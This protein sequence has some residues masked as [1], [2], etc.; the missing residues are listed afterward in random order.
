M[1][2]NEYIFI[3]LSSLGLGFIL[4]PLAIR[5]AHRF[6]WL[7]QPGHRKH[8][9]QAVA[10]LGG[11]A[12]FTSILLSLFLAWAL[13]FLS[14]METQAFEKIAIIL[15]CSLGLAVVGLWD[16]LH[17]VRA[18]YKLIGQVF[19]TALFA[20]FGFR[21]EVMHVPGLPPFPL[22][23]MSVPLTVFW[24][25]SV[26]NA[27]NMV[28]GLDGLASTIF[29]GSLLSLS[30]ASALAD[31]PG[32]MLLC[33]AAFGAVLGFLK[34]NWAPAKIYLGDCGSNGLAMLL[35]GLL[36]GLGQTHNWLPGI[37]HNP[38]TAGQPFHYQVFVLTLLVAY[39][40]LEIL[41][42]V[43]RRSLHGRPLGRA[44]RGHLHH[45]M[46]ALGLQK[47][48]ICLIALSF[49]L[50]TGWSA[51]AIIGHEFGR[52]TWLL[53][54]SGAL[55]GLSFPIL[56][57]LDF[58][59]PH[60]I[61]FTRP[62]FLISHHF[63]SMQKAKLGLVIHQDDVLQL[64]NQVCLEFGVQAYRLQ[65]PAGPGQYPCAAF[66]EKPMHEQKQYLTEIKTEILTG[67]FS[68]FKD[69]VEHKPT[70]GAANWIFEPHT[71]EDELDVEYHVLLS[72]FMREALERIAFLKPAPVPS[73]DSQP[74]RIPSPRLTS[75][76][77]RRRHRSKRAKV[78]L[79]ASGE[80]SLNDHSRLN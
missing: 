7:D 26:I 50:L 28:D 22:G 46:L 41:L 32:G 36:I 66:W 10:Y 6:S 40:A 57:F 78:P 1:I 56:G 68:V 70:L 5:L 35:G 24:L 69:R 21:F 19:F 52:A 44:D 17:Q 55:L 4:T 65:V 16:D 13:G 11:A 30:A 67:N 8:H 71:V 45:R 74:V 31:N 33:L 73:T 39:P 14:N 43:A 60:V 9:S 23:F 62:H 38:E 18:R 53:V 63:I 72:E 77:L 61:N 25:L 37:A 64:I 20:V 58:L 54:V 15:A 3:F 42:T 49:T 76:L 27:F 48:W 51:F 12:V 2:Y 34:F 29:A 80:V 59:K 75:S 47:K 79:A